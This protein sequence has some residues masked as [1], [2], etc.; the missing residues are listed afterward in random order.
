MMMRTAV[1]RVD[2]SA[3]AGATDCAEA[4]LECRRAVLLACVQFHC[5]RRFVTKGT[6]ELL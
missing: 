5:A 2:V 1:L 6:A 3:A 4:S